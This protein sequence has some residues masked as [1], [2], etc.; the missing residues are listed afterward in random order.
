MA[1]D[2]SFDD[3]IPSSQKTTDISFDDLIPKKSTSLVTKPD[4]RSKDKES[5][6]I[7]QGEKEK[8]S[9]ALSEA[10]R[11]KDKA[12]EDRAA[13]DIQSLD[14][15]IAATA[16]RAGVAT[17]EP[18]AVE[19]TLPARD[20]Q[21]RTPSLYDIKA[22]PVETKAAV[23]PTAPAADESKVSAAFS[24]KSK[25]AEGFKPR[26]EAMQAKVAQE[27]LAEENKIPF[28]ALTQSPAL[29]KTI[30]DYVLAR[31]GKSELQKPNESTEDY[32][33]RFAQQMRFL[34]TG[35]TLSLT[36]EAQ[37]LNSAKDDDKL[38]VGA[39]YALWDNVADPSFMTAGGKGQKGIRPVTDSLLA[40]FTDPLTLV[41]L[42]TG[43]VVA[44]PIQR[45]VA[46]QGIKK[47][48]ISNVG[49]VAAIPAVET[50]Q[51]V[52]SD[53]LQQKAELD[54]AA[55]QLRAAEARF[56]SLEPEQQQELQPQLD[57]LRKKVEEGISLKQAAISGA[58][59]GVL[60]TAE[61]AGILKA[62]KKLGGGQSSLDEILTRKKAE[63][64]EAPAPKLE[65][66]PSTGTQKQLEDDYDIFEGRNLLDKQLINLEGLSGMEY[67]KAFAKNE[68]AV[69]QMQVRKEINRKATQL[70]Q[71]V[72]TS[73]PEFAPKQGEKIS[74]AVKNVFLNIDNVDDVALKD[75]FAKANITPE[76]FARMN[77]TTVSDAAST[78]QS[79]SV[80]ARIQ[81]KLKS[82]DPAAAKEVDLMYGN[83]NAITD[84]FGFIKDISMRA[85][86]E[87]KAL[88]VSQ[89]ATTV[90]NAYSGLTV[91]TFGAAS[92]AVESALYRI[93][94]T[95]AEIYTGKPVTGSFTNG[96]KGVWN[97]AFRTASYLSDAGLS[98]DVAEK[99]LGGSPT[100][101]SLILKTAGEAGDQGLSRV[102]QI[103]N[104]FNVAQDAFFRRAIFS[105]NVEKQ[106]NRVGIDM[107]SVLA[108]DKNIPLDVLKNATNEALLATFSKMPT[109]GPVYH[110]VKFVEELG[111][112]GS[113]LIPFPRFMA[114]AMEW[115]ATHSPIGLVSGSVDIASKDLNKRM[116]GLEKLSKGIVGTGAI[117]A[118]YKYRKDNQDTE[119]YDAKN[120]DGSLVDTRAFFPVAPFLALGDYLVKLENGT[121]SEFKAKELFEAVTGFKMPA[122]TSNW[123]GDQFATAASN[124]QASATGEDVAQKKVSTFFG[125]WAGQYFG[126]ALIPLQQLSDIIGAVD[127]NETLPRSVYEIKQGEEGFIPSAKNVLMSK[128]PVLK[129]ELPV[130]QP[131]TKT[132]AS[133]ND[134]GL[135][136]MFAGISIKVNPTDFEKEITRLNVPYNKLFTTT[137][138]KVVDRQAKEILA[139]QLIA[140]YEALASTDFYKNTNKD[141]QKIALENTLAG[142][143]KEAKAVAVDMA[144]AKA[145]EGGLGAARVI[146]NRYAAKPAEVK[147][148]AAA[149]YKQNTGK[150]LT[151]TGDYEAGLAYA[152]AVQNILKP[153]T[154]KAT[155]GVVGYTGGGVVAK[156]LAGEAVERGITKIG[157]DLLQ[158]MD[159]M[160]GKK[161]GTEIEETAAALKA[162][163]ETALG[164][165]VVEPAESISST[166]RPVFRPT[167]TSKVVKDE[168]PYLGDVEREGRFVDAPEPILSKAET[169]AAEEVPVWKQQYDL[170][171]KYEAQGED[172][173]DFDPDTPFSWNN[174]EKA[175]PVVKQERETTPSIP[176]S[177]LK[178]GE[179]DETFKY[180]LTDQKKKKAVLS[181]LRERRGYDFDKLIKIPEIKDLPDAEDVLAVVQGDFRKYEKREIDPKKDIDLVV[182]MAKKA[183]SKLDVLRKKYAD[184]P[185]IRIIH[186]RDAS[187]G[188]SNTR[189]KTG[190][191]DPME[192]GNYHNELQIGGTS[193]TRDLNLN[194]E[195]PTFGGPNPEQIVYTEMPYADFMFKRVNMSPEMYAKKSLDTIAQTINGSDRVIRPLSLPRT[196]F[197]ETEEVITETDKL[198]P[199]G[200]GT[201]KQLEIKSGKE[202]VTQAMYG[203]EKS[204]KGFLSRQKREQEILSELLDI[205]RNMDRPLDKRVVFTDGKEEVKYISDDVLARRAY[206]NI[207]KLLNNYMEKGELASTKSGL[208]QRYQTAIDLAAR[209]TTMVPETV[210]TSDGTKVMGKQQPLFF[211]RLLDTVEETL[212]AS[213][214]KEKS[215]LLG[216]INN[217]LD[218]FR[219]EGY[220][221][222]YENPAFRTPQIKATNKIR[223]LT[224]KLAKGGLVGRR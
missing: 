113:T 8:A 79:Y 114:N 89:I 1:Y 62:G 39:A 106:L 60:G 218:A 187:K 97:D 198:A 183:Q 135:L 192:Y 6:S 22:A 148:Q 4:Q 104:T 53:T 50:A 2:I 81:N 144:R 82:I 169:P 133:F 168:G 224:Q 174:P 29:K 194:L 19:P 117:Y 34:K 209:E 161:V 193:F 11:L 123:L 127:R 56:P 69:A 137:G 215:K 206:D 182:D 41:S 162:T 180:A 221:M 54:I 73:L 197:K 110:A 207:K 217:E 23:A 204:Q 48:L 92:E 196:N 208:G 166:K 9:I 24:F 152:T 77:R 51:G 223:E 214:A 85:D 42:G 111:P 17:T 14:R 61:A 132:E 101:K 150:D 157:G 212:K 139:P 145:I 107:Y 78:M 118:A 16:K 35:N 13:A 173:G 158:Q 219:S 18:V 66:K 205:Q 176:D 21:V 201:G 112:V 109:K 5:L 94:K 91:V 122:G 153:S 33:N 178:E 131:V 74:D 191:I 147:R 175:K 55:A 165:S 44:A 177:K 12:R 96:I 108:Q 98:A 75:A 202:L 184:E 57:A 179:F 28:D 67:E 134:A 171:K 146:E 220:R 83:R 103:A 140:S 37:F 27:R 138:D 185:P 76:E 38:K 36:S 25:L 68:S 210:V 116:A 167:S 211:K 63:L 128:V 90:R 15:E 172:V 195:S 80:L 45:A 151:E 163:R 105:A 99:L 154:N 47:A 142:V 43:K 52:A 84:S 93:G 30:D 136:K 213:G 86:K 160:L 102:G 32:V 100:L 95:S 164:K 141:L 64:P 130:A 190:F 126:R 115:T 159:V 26:A 156:K 71:E 189:Y 31:F 188:G 88:M 72:W 143:Q 120:T 129:Q 222:D 87:L 125:E 59:S 49:K 119:W 181:S 155:G 70:A 40:M 203:N 199:E 20:K 170:Y 121:T 124:W 46:E 7:L 186:G 3:L 216:Q 200:K 149:L 65:I 58:V 10:Q